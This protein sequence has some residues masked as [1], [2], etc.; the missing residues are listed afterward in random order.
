MKV[1]TY[2]E[3]QWNEDG[4]FTLVRE[5]SFEY[6][7]PVAECKT[8]TSANVPDPTP[9]ERRLT[10]IMGDIAS[11][12]LN[13]ILG[14]TF[15]Q[16]QLYSMTP[17]LLRS[18]GEDLGVGSLGFG[19]APMIGSTPLSSFGDVT[20]GGT[21]GPVGRVAREVGNR[22]AGS[23]PALDPVA[24]AAGLGIAPQQSTAAPVPFTNWNNWVTTPDGKM[25]PPSSVMFRAQP[26]PPSGGAATA[27]GS[28]ASIGLA[29]GGVPNFTDALL[30][31]DFGRVMRSGEASDYERSLID[32][33]ISEAIGAG[34]S[35]IDAAFT[36]TLGLLSQE[37]A[38]S[39]GMRMSDSPILDRGSKLA[40]EAIRQKSQLARNLRTQGAQ[41][42]LEF[43]L[44]RGEAMRVSSDALKTFQEELRQRAFSN[45]AAML[46]AIQSG[47]LGLAGA[48]G[49]AGGNALS[50]LTQSRLAG[51][52]TS[53][54]NPAGLAAGVGSLL[55]GAGAAGLLSSRRFKTNNTP[56]DED[57]VLRRLMRLPVERWT[58]RNSDEPH[59]GTYAEDFTKL[60]KVGDGV[61]LNMI[62]AMGVLMASVKALARKV[63]VLNARLG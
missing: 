14:Q 62:D 43:P 28:S 33:A 54:S 52:S 29:S 8:K 13:A 12:Q 7:G 32:S 2:A 9:E 53:S 49:N 60:F 16:N 57:D 61:M 24:Q 4:S 3:Y 39:R 25:A 40:M 11:Q 46:G 44:R 31:S 45:R 26:V 15:F 42:M 63:E 35:D 36:D 21:L 17:Q 58:Y 22:R 20:G 47:G 50:A 23:R 37:V 6:H 34:S 10:G 51:T 41:Q 5:D 30:A 27:G 38:P 19:A 1:A 59:I 48:G 56:L 55:Y 18:I